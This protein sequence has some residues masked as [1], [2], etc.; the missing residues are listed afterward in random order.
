MSTYD[1]DVG[2]C[3]G[4]KLALSNGT[5]KNVFFEEKSY[6]LNNEKL[7]KFFSFYIY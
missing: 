5:K 6:T 3:V 2:G 7:I 1:V 4:G